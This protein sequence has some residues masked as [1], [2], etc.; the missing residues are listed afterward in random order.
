[1]TN[2]MFSRHLVVVV[3]WVG[4]LTTHV[5]AQASNWTS[6]VALRSGASV[7]VE[8]SAGAVQKGQFLQADDNNLAI[9]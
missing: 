4:V 6:V 8:S 2:L 5:A 7:R 3:M 1:M 9:T